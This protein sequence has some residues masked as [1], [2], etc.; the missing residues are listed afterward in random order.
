LVAADPRLDLETPLTPAD[1][2]AGIIVC[3]GEYL[4]QLRDTKHGIFFPGAWGCFGGAVEEG[5]T[6][7][8]AFVRE[9][10]E[11]L[12]WAPTSDVVNRFNRI[13]FDVPSASIPTLWRVYFEVEVTGE[14]IAAFRLREGSA[15][16]LFAPDVIL[17]GSVPLVPYDAF[18][19]WLHINR[20]RLRASR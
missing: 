7:Q 1:A 9:L 16:R 6:P 8:D 11:E 19:L 2:V 5:E 17:T 15:L 3:D 13:A 12:G 18:V 4:L 20:H 10:T 14:L